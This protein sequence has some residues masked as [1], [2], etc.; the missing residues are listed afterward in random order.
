MEALYAFVIKGGLSGVV[1]CEL[2]L[3][4]IL[5]VRRWVGL[6]FWCGGCLVLKL[7]EYLCGVPGN[8][9][10]C[11]VV[12]IIPCDHDATI[13]GAV[14]IGLDTLIFFFEACEKVFCVL[15]SCVFYAEVVDNEANS[16]GVPFV[17]PYDWCE[18]AL[19]V[20]MFAKALLEKII[21]KFAGLWQAIYAFMDLDVDVTISNHGLEAV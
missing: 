1:C 19:M 17:S 13:E 18:S 14:P 10:V 4:T 21:C 16:D 20:A 8:A 2:D 6:V 7:V 15:G 12:G 9:D 11:S 3:H 5:T